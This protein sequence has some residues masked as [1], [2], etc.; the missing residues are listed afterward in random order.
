MNL[1]SKYFFNSLFFLE[2]MNFKFIIRLNISRTATSSILHNS[3]TSSIVIWEWVRFNYNSTD[4]IDCLNIIQF[5]NHS[6]FSHMSDKTK[7][8]PHSMH[9]HKIRYSEDIPKISFRDTIS[10]ECLFG[11]GFY[12]YITLWLKE[13]WDKKCNYFA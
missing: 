12:N 9:M 3:A 5:F 11:N 13:N 6:L 10:S 2:Y 8:I 4:N 7:L 1:Y